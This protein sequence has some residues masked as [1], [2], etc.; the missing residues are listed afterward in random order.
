MKKAIPGLQCDDDENDDDLVPSDDAVPEDDDDSVPDD[1]WKCLKD[2]TD[3][4]SC[5]DGGCTWCDTKAGYGICMDKEAA[6]SASKSDWFDCKMSA[7]SLR[8]PYD[9][10]C[11]AASLQG[12]EATCEAT[13]GQDGQA[14]EWC[15]VSSVNFC[16]TQDQ[17]EIAEQLG[18]D[19]AETGVVEDKGQI[20]D[21]YDTSCL[22][23][24]LQGD[25]TTC[26]ATLDQDGQVCEWCSV[27]SVNL[28]LTQDQAEIAEQLGGNCSDEGKSRVRTSGSVS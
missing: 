8:D 4:G 19:C 13:Q 3:S 24:S 20:S 11:L 2:F 18:G 5:S 25:E 26:E 7:L 12:D 23:A 10:S 1:Y 28:C 17:A 14:C 22:A 15:S 27:S 21:P 6:E 9:T 16:L